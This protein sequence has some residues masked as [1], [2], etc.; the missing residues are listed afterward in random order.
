MLCAQAAEQII[1]N[2]VK[3]FTPWCASCEL[4][5]F[6]VRMGIGVLYSKH[7]VEILCTELSYPYTIVILWLTIAGWP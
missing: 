5:G 4:G 7:V 1:L 3:K 6:G 2:L